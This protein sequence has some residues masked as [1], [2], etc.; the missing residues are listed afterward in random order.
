VIEDQR[1][2]EFGFLVVFDAQD[3]W[4]IDAFQHLELAACLAE[5]AARTSGLDAVARV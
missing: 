3:A 4:M 2:A 5:R 1:R